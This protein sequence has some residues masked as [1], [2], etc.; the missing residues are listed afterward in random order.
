MRL[1]SRVVSNVADH[2]SFLLFDHQAGAI[3]GV[4]LNDGGADGEDEIWLSVR[5]PPGPDVPPQADNAWLAPW[6]NVKLFTLQQELAGALIEGQL[7]LVW[8]MGLGV[9]RKSGTAFAYP[10]VT[11]LVDLSFDAGSQA[12]QV[13]PRDLDPR[14]ELEFFSQ[15]EGPATTQ[16]EKAAVEVVQNTGQ[17]EW[18]ADA[19]GVGP[20]YAPRFTDDDIARLREARRQLGGDIDYAGNV[21]PVP[22]DF[23]DKLQLANAHDELLRFTALTAQ[24]RASELPVRVTDLRELCESPI[25]RGG[26][27][28]RRMTETRRV[29][30]PETVDA[31]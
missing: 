13:R 11:R 30:A 25:E 22:A 14:L 17:F 27:G 23:P 4:R 15:A 6:L 3:E 21:L 7:E 19:L 1:R 16:A 12:A 24:A 2:G 5:H 8:G 20:Q 18:I 10:L 29:R 26:W 31:T 28:R 9:A